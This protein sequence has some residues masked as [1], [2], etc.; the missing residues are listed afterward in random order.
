M[1]SAL[2]RTLAPLLL[3]GLTAACLPRLSIELPAGSD[4]TGLPDGGSPDG[5]GDTAAGDVQLEGISPED[6]P[7]S[8]GTAVEILG[9]PFDSA[10]QVTFGHA[11][12]TVEQTK[13]TRMVVSAP[14][15]SGGAPG[16]VDLR[17]TTAT[18]SASLPQAFHYW[19]DA[20]GDAVL[21]ADWTQLVVADP[22]SWTDRTPTFDAWVRFTGPTAAGP[23][24]RYGVVPGH[25][26]PPIDGTSSL[27][28]PDQ[29]L[30][31]FGTTTALGLT[32][33]TER[34]EY[35]WQD[36]STP[37][38]LIG[39]PLL[40]QAARSTRSPDL[41]L[42][43]VVTSA[44]QL[45]VTSPDLRSGIPDVKA[46]QADISWVQDSYDHVMIMGGT[47]SQAAFV[48]ILDDN[49]SFTIPP[50]TFAGLPWVTATD[51]SSAVTIWLA[52]VGYNLGEAPL[53]WTNGV[54]RVEAGTGV[55][56]QVNLF[57]DPTGKP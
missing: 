35:T 36:S 4:D 51:G 16:A 8:G 11:T 18:A 15:A 53:D 57:T 9:G 32:W 44:D 20:G 26:G 1:R 24:A 12:A 42:A 54:A 7:T 3:C 6:G 34:S 38:I 56:G 41:D 43:A 25:C 28:G 29:V 21:L 40:L 22:G 49:G 50:D 2:P 23:D 14:P 45:S 10:T 5:G 13:P 48:C 27:Q 47:A 33:S 30:L 39:Q 52:V 17:V 31:G 37:P 55:L 46:T 19:T